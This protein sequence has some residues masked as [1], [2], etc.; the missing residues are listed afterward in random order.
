MARVAR[1]ISIP[2]RLGKDLLTVVWGADPA[3]SLAPIARTWV[4]SL[5]LAA[6]VGLVAIAGQ[7]L[8][9]T[10]DLSSPVSM[11]LGVMTV[12]PLAV[13]RRKPLWA[14][15]IAF[16]GLLIGGIG[17][18]QLEAWPWNPVQALA[19]V[20]ILFVVALREPPGVIFWVGVSAV[21]IVWFRVGSENI[22]GVTVL[23]AVLLVLG[24]QIGRRRRIQRALVVQSERGEIAEAR[25]AVL[26]ERTRIARELH[27]VVAHSM[28]LV[29]VRAETAPYRLPGL[30]EPAREEFL[31]LA[32]TARDSLTELRRLLG[33]L[34]TD[35][36]QAELAPQPDLSDLDDLVGSARQAGMQV[37]T[38]IS[39]GTPSA[40]TGLTVVPNRAGGAVERGPARFGRAGAGDGD[41]DE[42]AD[43]GRGAQRAWR[44]VPPHPRH[45]SRAGRHA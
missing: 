39:G 2:E 27:D 25:E 20:V 40:A 26:V 9:D 24:E 13:L 29:A 4:R 41:H 36:T 10:R 37:M 38:S 28:S 11:A 1:M 14:W 16:L 44:A 35:Q 32:G 7:Y 6:G 34:R 42:D 19:A 3:P 33:V 15:R 17:Q 31:A 5:M 18:T 12:L 22:A 8:S 45:R 23:L 43:P 21:L 30:S